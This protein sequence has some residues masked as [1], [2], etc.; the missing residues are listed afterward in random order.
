[1]SGQKYSIDLLLVIFLALVFL[2]EKPTEANVII[3]CK[4]SERQA[5]LDFN[6]CLAAVNGSDTGISSWGS[7]D[8]N[9]DCCTWI[10]VGCSVSTGHV[11]K[12]DLLGLIGNVTGTISTSLLEL[13]YL[14]YLDLSFNDFNGYPIPE[15]IGSLRE[16]TNLFFSE[17]QFSGSIPSQLGNLSRLVTLDLSSNQLTGSIPESFRNLVALRELS[18][19]ANL[20]D[21]G[22]PKSLWNICSLHSLNLRS[23]NLGGDVFGFL[24]STSLCTTYSLEELELSENQFTGSV[25]NEITKLSSLRVLS[26]RYNRLNGTISQD[27]GQLSNI[28]TLELPGNS[29]DEVVLSEA[30]FSNLSNLRKLDLSDSSLALK[31]NSDWIPPFQLHVIYLRSC[32]LG[33][34]FP[35]W[36][37]SQDMPYEI[38]LSASGISD[39]IP[40]WFWN[41]SSLVNN[42]NL[43]FNQISGSLPHNCS[44]RVSENKCCICGP[45]IDLS[46]NNLTGPLP[47]LP[48]VSVS[49]NLS[50][51]KFFGSITSICDTDL[52]GLLDLSNN[53]FSGVIPNCFARWN[54]IT[55]LNLAENNLSGSIPRSIGS[56]TNLRMVSLRSN[57]LSVRFPSSLWK[58]F[59]LKF[60]DLSDNKL[61]GNIPE[62]IGEFSLLIFLSLRTNQFRGSMPHQLC[63]LS[64]LQI[65]D[66]SLNKISGTIPQCLNNF[67]SMAQNVNLSRTIEHAVSRKLDPNSNFYDLNYVDEAQLTWKG[68]KQKYAKILGLLLVIDLSSNKLTGKIPE[69]LTSLRG[70]VALN[71]SRNILTGKIPRKIGQLRQLQTL[72]LSRNKF[73]G[74]IPPSLSELTFLGSLDLSY[75]YLSGK[76]PTGSQLQ[77]FDPSSFSHNHGLCGPPVTPNC[78][79]SVE[80][81]QGQPGRY[82]DDFDEFRKW[83][84][85]GM[86]F[87]FAVGFWGFCGPVLFKRSWRH[88]YFRFLDNV[89]DWLYLAFLLHKA[90]L[91]RRI[92]A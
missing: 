72:D 39:S 56:L 67:T 70:L 23:N 92:Q 19:K 26:L 29:F 40:T 7:E 50:K 58:C 73:S 37:R 36:I 6:Q 38:D 8:D 16:L 85:A 49:L 90:R 1:M 69:Q 33:P 2:L 30:H 44:F 83:F 21:G 78:S 74:S 17:S 32:K 64:H 51:N 55:T 34:R 35:Q 88:S 59:M 66:L 25:P 13:R 22:I 61:S 53:L 79:E 18:L 47:Q 27:I 5:V 57:N 41:T 62:W 14:S 91:E 45:F 60:L 12:L 31:F 48:I 28:S 10:G 42:L 46:S 24:R 71:L 82:Q 87:G 20:L 4:E 9:G 54:G 76:I 75:N 84:Y 11:V 3:R 52:I 65:L 15:F 43:S 63:E 81:P 77:L 80:K 89:K 68:M 86:G